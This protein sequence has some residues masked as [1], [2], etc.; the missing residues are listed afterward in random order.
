[1]NSFFLKAEGKYKKIMFSDILFVEG[2]KN[3][4]Y[5][6][7]SKDRFVVHYTLKQIEESLPAAHFVRI[8]KSYIIA[9]DRI[10]A[11]D[12]EAI[13]IEKI[14]LPLS[15]GFTRALKSKLNIVCNEK[16]KMTGFPISDAVI[17]H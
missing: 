15:A 5:I 4:V 12:S 16:K 13:Y 3:Y 6:Q 10:T 1:M 17:S 2:N 11:F 14:Q 7:T 8:H 9:V